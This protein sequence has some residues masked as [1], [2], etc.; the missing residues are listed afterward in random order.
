MWPEGMGQDEIHVPGQ[1]NAAQILSS[2]GDGFNSMDD[3]GF[4]IPGPPGSGAHS[5][6]AGR[7]VS[8]R[9]PGASASGFAPPAAPARPS[10]PS[11]RGPAAPP[12]RGPPP[13]E[14]LAGQ[15]LQAH[16]PDE[17]VV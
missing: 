5:M 6:R 3:L 11:A 9:R 12:S 8:M 17:H 10:L 1:S 13:F 4:R 2:S 7:R 15:S 14:V 16:V